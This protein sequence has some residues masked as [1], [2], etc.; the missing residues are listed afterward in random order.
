MWGVYRFKNGFGGEVI[1]TIGAWD[2]PVKP[3]LYKLYT[4]LLPM[5]LNA[6]RKIG[7]S[8]IESAAA[9]DRNL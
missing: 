5:I 9:E 1:R 3:L 4:R 6:F 7:D 2:Y 8:K